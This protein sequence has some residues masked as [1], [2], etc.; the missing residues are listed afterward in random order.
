MTKEKGYTI[1]GAKFALKNI[2]TK[3]GDIITEL[4]SIKNDLKE[5]LDLID[6]KI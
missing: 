3:T 1:D 2:N 4:I 6:N 5:L